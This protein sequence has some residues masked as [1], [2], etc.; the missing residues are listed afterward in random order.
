MPE[1]L[2]FLCQNKAAIDGVE[3]IWKEEWYLH[4]ASH[5]HFYTTGHVSAYWVRNQ[6]A[7]SE[8]W[9]LLV[10]AVYPWSGKSL[11]LL[12]TR[13]WKHRNLQK[14]KEKTFVFLNIFLYQKQYLNR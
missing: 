7:I 1:N 2:L 12:E 3:Q 4:P 11:R 8:Y 5:I 9:L 14:K 10:W 6:Y 13:P